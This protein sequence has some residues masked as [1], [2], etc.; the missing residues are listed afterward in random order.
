MKVTQVLITEHHLILKVLNL[1]KKS[2]EDLENGR[3]IPRVFYEKAMTFCSEFADQFHHFKEEFLLFGLLSYK[4]KGTLDSVMG[5][6]R[7]QHE[8]CRQSIAGIRQALDG[9][10]E[11][12]E[13]ATTLLLES[14]AVYVS[15]LRRHIYLEDQIFFPMAEK[16]LSDDE[17]KSLAEQ[18]EN[19]E[20][21][22]NAKGSVFDRNLIIVDELAMIMKSR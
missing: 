21:R 3:V 22:N 7:Y 12:D 8:T 5:T 6:L 13:M 1:L 18:F 4:K 15:L 19:E 11:K 17:K 20:K 9:Y 2:R 14:L 16:A 10:E